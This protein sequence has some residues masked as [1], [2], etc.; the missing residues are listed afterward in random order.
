MKQRIIDILDGKAKYFSAIADYIWDNPELAFAEHKS[1][2]A[3]TDALT[4]NGFKVEMGLAGM[5]TAFKGVFGSGRPVIGFLAEYDALSSMSQK[6]GIPYEEAIDAGAPGHGCGHNAIGVSCVA[7]AVAMKSVMEENKLS[8]TLIVYGCPG[9]EGGAG[10]AFMARD[11]VFGDMDIAM[12]PHPAENNFI[13][14]ISA[15][16]NV[17]VK[18]SFKGKAAH[19]GAVP[20]LGRSALDACSLMIVGT[21]FLREHI[22][23]EAR[24]HHAY[25]NAGGTAPNVVQADASLVFYVRA[26]KSSEVKEIFERVNDI[27][28][29]A[30]LMTGTTVEIELQS[31]VN[32]LLVNEVVGSTLAEAWA[33]I[34]PQ[35]FS[36]EAF[37]AAKVMA[38]VI[39]NCDLDEPLDESIPTFKKQNTSMSGSTDVGDAS[40]IAPTVMFMHAALCKCT[41][42]HTWQ[43]VAQSRSPIMHEGMIHA[44]KVMALTGLKFIQDPKLVERAWKEHKESGAKYESLI[45]SD[46]K[47]NIPKE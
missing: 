3:L 26:P 35:R 22:I 13:M 24:I 8:G 47:P 30:A 2:K 34:G 36:K 21:Q 40:Y 16:A 14:G 5:P 18:Y 25:L 17:H 45:P 27:A 4:E 29:G 23:P 6:D 10:K 15:L 7:A 41:P 19:A 12:A 39:P 31:G 38:P 20:H 44:A 11:G 32:N 43:L 1:A 42:G 46:I 9:E 37:L 28:R 33:E